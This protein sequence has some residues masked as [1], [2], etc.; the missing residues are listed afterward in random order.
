MKLIFEIL[1]LVLLWFIWI[2]YAIRKIVEISFK[3]YGDTQWW[4]FPLCL[5][6]GFTPIIISAYL[7]L[8]Q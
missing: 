4:S 6:A 8:G 5:I 7:I 3:M 2:E 1:I